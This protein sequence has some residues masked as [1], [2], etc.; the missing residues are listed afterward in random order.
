MTL[1][2]LYS[3][4]YLEQE[5]E[6]YKQM[7]LSLREQAERITPVLSDMPRGGGTND[8]VGNL[9]TEIALYTDFLE[10][11]MAKKVEQQRKIHL[12]IEGVDDPVV[13][14][15]MFKRF[16]EQKKWR[17]VADEMG[18]LNTEDSVRKKCERYV[19][20]RRCGLS[21]MSA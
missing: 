18:G 12:Y 10:K 13:R 3:E 4:P 15:I 7:I 5:I 11:A 16:V 17:Q 19:Q 14:R 1:Q 9:A 20:K 2:E 8:K 6:D 21:D